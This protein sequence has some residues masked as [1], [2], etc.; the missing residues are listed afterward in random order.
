M[1]AGLVVGFGVLRVGKLVRAGLGDAV[2][3][4]LVVVAAPLEKA[5]IGIVSVHRSSCSQLRAGMGVGQE[6]VK[7]NEPSDAPLTPGWQFG[8][9]GFA[10]LARSLG[11][12]AASAPLYRPL[13]HPTTPMLDLLRVGSSFRSGR[14]PGVPAIFRQE[15]NR[16][17]TRPSRWN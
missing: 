7:V 12:G 5:D 10:N 4:I 8:R 17:I 2:A 14:Y 13:R 9:C 11:T 16:Y 3:D 15:S 6:P 1:L